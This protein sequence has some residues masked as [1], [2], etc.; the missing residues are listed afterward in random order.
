VDRPLRDAKVRE[1]DDLVEENLNDPHILIEVLDE[2]GFRRTRAAERLARRIRNR[3]DYIANPHASP[4]KQGPKQSP[5]PLII[6]CQCGRSLRV[7]RPQEPEVAI[8]CPNCGQ[9]YD[10]TKNDDQ[11]VVVARIAPQF[12]D[13]RDN[14][15]FE[16]QDPYQ[17][18]GLPPRASASEIRQAYRGMVL[19]YHP[20]KTSSLGPKL[21]EVAEEEMKK[22][23]WAYRTLMEAS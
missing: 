17:I 15:R 22:I 6:P 5:G 11:V 21:R 8:R 16:E 14:G 18:L 19:Q 4:E 10:I 20:D 7:Q 13:N 2:L 9:I 12:R 3:L 23:N 1:L